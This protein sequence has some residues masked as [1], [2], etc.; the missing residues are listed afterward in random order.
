MLELTDVLTNDVLE[1]ITFVL[2][3]PTVQNFEISALGKS[4]I[5]VFWVIRNHVVWQVGTIFLEAYTA[6]LYPRRGGCIFLHISGRHL[7]SYKSVVPNCHN[8]QNDNKILLC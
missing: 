6:S 2:A 1:P 4:I 3:Y 5:V 8:P 7:L